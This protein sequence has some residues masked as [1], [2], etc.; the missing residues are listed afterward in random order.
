MKF[1]MEKIQITSSFTGWDIKGKKMKTLKLCYKLIYDAKNKKFKAIR[2][3]K[4][5][6]KKLKYTWYLECETENEKE[7]ALKDLNH[8]IEKLKDDLDEEKLIKFCG[9]KKL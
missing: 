3:S 6:A 7:T 8:L 4:T 5:E 2:I 1:L 9:E